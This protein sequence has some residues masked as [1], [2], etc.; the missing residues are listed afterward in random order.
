MTRKLEA[1]APWQFLGLPLRQLSSL[2]EQDHRPWPLPRGPWRLGQTWEYLLFAHW[3]ADHAALARLVPSSLEVETFDGTAW[4][5]VVPFVIKGLRLAMTPPLPVLSAFPE[6]NV[7]TY[8]T[9]GE[10]PGVWFFSLDAGSRLA[11]VAARQMYHL[12]YFHAAMKACGSRDGVRF[13]SVRRDGQHR[14]RAT[15]RPVGPRARPRPGSL[16]H[17]LTERYCLYAVEAG[18]LYRGEIHHGPW[19]LQAAAGAIDENTM[20]PVS[21]EEEP[22]LHFARRQDVLVWPAAPAR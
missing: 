2:G 12:P 16:E 10:K 14:F 4:L 7:R 9:D 8:V 17:F 15:Y 18:T 3:R 20:A 5:G 22:L 11:V 21:L 13:A 19:G 6:L 1:S